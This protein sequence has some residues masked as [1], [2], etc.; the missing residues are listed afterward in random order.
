MLKHSY[1]S[2]LTFGPTRRLLR[3][4]RAGL[5]TVAGYSDPFFDLAGIGT[6][7][8]ASLFLDIG[9]HHGDTLLRFLESGLKTQIAAFDP[10]PQN[11]VIAKSKLVSHSHISFVQAAVSD[12][13]GQA[14][15]FV[16]RNEQTSS[17]LENAIGNINSFPEGTRHES[18][19]DVQTIRLDSW[20]NSC[21]DSAS[22][23]CIKCDTQGAE[24][25]VITG[26]LNTIRDKVCAFYSEVMLGPMYEGQ[27]SFEEM[28]NLLENQCGMVLKN[29]YPCLHDSSGRA[30]QMDVLWVKPEYL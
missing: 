17:L 4:A 11:L 14:R 7:S 24:A 21:K 10:L 3:R 18:S 15:F 19:I 22:R 12:Y 25:K 28:R 16:N 2:L 5:Q 6:R 20:I 26:G 9:C 1:Q 23:I 29:I 27:A 8:Q 30:V 13:D